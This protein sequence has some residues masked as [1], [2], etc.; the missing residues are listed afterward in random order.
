MMRHLNKPISLLAVILLFGSIIL[1]GC[2]DDPEETTVESFASNSTTVPFS[3]VTEEDNTKVTMVSASNSYSTDQRLERD[4]WKIA[5][6]DYIKGGDG[7]Y[8]RN[9]YPNAWDEYTYFTLVDVDGDEIPE[10]YR[11]GGYVAQGE[12]LVTYANGKLKVINSYASG[13]F[14][15]GNSGYLWREERDRENDIEYYRHYKYDKGNLTLLLEAAEIDETASRKQKY[16]W[17]GKEVSEEVF[18][19][20]INEINDNSKSYTDS[21]LYDDIIQAINQF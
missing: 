11:Q 20:H 4:A 15:Q 1:S 14:F 8:S 13:Y 12:A 18:R 19:S 5:Y 6:I 3:N 10:L 9:P 21:L 2:F 17:D 7:E 16:V